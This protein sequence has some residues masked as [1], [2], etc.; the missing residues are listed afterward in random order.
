MFKN[1][2]RNVV[3]VVVMALGIVI[4]FFAF[5]GT[6]HVTSSVPSATPFQMVGCN[7]IKDTDGMLWFD[8]SHQGEPYVI[9]DSGYIYQPY[10]F[11][12]FRADCVQG[13]PRVVMG[14]ADPN[15]ANQDIHWETDGGWSCTMTAGYWTFQV[16]GSYFW[17][18][19]KPEHY[20]DPRPIIPALPTPAIDNSGQNG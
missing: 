16:G 10:F 17:P 5:S 1:N 4:M 14:S 12:Y 7:A 2:V 18:R 9:T 19:G 13:V 20:V 11:A 15:C 8:K 6:V 3:F